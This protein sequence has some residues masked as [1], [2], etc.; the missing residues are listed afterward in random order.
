MKYSVLDL[1]PVPEG[2]D[3]VQAMK[4]TGDLAQRAEA[5]GYHRYWMAEHHNM[6]GIASA[7]T[8]VLIGHVAGLT[9]RI[10]VGAGGIMLPNHAP[11]TVA[12][13]FGTLATLYGDRIDLGLGRAPGGDPAV[14]HALRRA[15]SDDFAGDVAEL[16][17]YLGDPHPDAPVRALPGEGTR[18]PVWILGSS[19]YGA[20]LAAQM[21]L[22]Y[23][24]ASHFAPDALDQAA[25]MYRRYFKPSVHLDAPKFML[26]INVFGADSDEEGAY[27]RSTMQQAFA[28]LRTG[29]RGKLPRPVRDIDAAIGAGMRR[30]VDQALRVSAVGSADTIKRQLAEWIERYAPDEVILTGQI[31]DHAARV[32]SFAMAAEA[33]D[34]LA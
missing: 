32:K 20:Q 7:A 1:A 8:S 9:R 16:I 6:P 15:G 22:P 27:L 23:A 2:T 14:Y 21:G 5:L 4:N 34:S 13:Q 33:L 26:A 12:E 18:V 25:E 24:F 3:A 29:Q 31:H 10:R 11:L 17:G 30:A 28:R 19:L